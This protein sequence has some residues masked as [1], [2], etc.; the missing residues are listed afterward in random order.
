MNRSKG[1]LKFLFI[2]TAVLGLGGVLEPLSLEAADYPNILLITIDT[3]R[4]D[5]LSC[6]DPAHVATPNIDRLAERGVLFQK[7]FAHTPLTLPSHA[8]ILLG[9]SPVSHGVH[10]NSSFSVP[11]EH[12]TLAEYLKG[13]GYH[14][15][16]FVS[17]TPL[18]SRF[19][20]AQGFDI[21][22]DTFMP[23]GAPKIIGAEQIAESA[24]KKVLGWYKNVKKGPWF[25][26]VHLY[27]PHGDYEPPEPFRL[28]YM[29]RPYEGEVA[30]TDACLGQ[31][32]DRLD[33]DKALGRTIV[34]L[35][36]DHGESLGEH[37][38]DTHG[39][40]AY[41][42]VLHVPL[43]IAAPGVKKRQTDE[44]ACHSDIWPTLCDLAGIDVPGDLQGISLRP[45]LHGK[46]LPSRL[47]YFESLHS[48]YTFGWAPIQGY[49]NSD[50]KFI[51]SPI[52]EH[53]NLAADFDETT[54]LALDATDLSLQKSQLGGLIKRLTPLKSL[55][56]RSTTSP[57][58]LKKLES[59]GYVSSTAARHKTTFGPE[60]DC[61]TLFPILSRTK[62]AYLLKNEGKITEAIRLLES[63]R[64]EPLVVETLYL[65]LSGL[66][67]SVENKTKA[68]A[69]LD[70]GR[71][72]FPENYEILAASVDLLAAANRPLD[73][74]RVMNDAP[75]MMK[76]DQDATI[77]NLLGKAHVQLNDLGNA[78]EVFE[79][80]V[81]V[82]NEFIEALYNLASSRFDL[83]VKTH[84]LALCASAIPPLKR[85]IDLDARNAKAYHLL[86]NAYLESGE[87][88]FAISACNQALNINPAL[89]Q[90]YHSLGMAFYTKGHLAKA[91]EY[92]QIYKS[93]TYDVLSIM[94]QKNLD[95]LIQKCLPRER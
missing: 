61:K 48:Y 89:D 92:L 40:F 95:L 19:G 39:I 36:S 32:F 65:S 46:T 76:M 13:F 1:I 77:W 59:L 66:Y 25:L 81:S 72:R 90:A 47:I 67:L 57:A 18:D 20:L 62:K 52:P 11:Q 70:E 38:E 27:D 12:Q 58:L 55:N 29:A 74:I 9:V 22:D 42:S 24:I 6:Y 78:I 44:L 64:D 31:L 94:E 7:A 3:L 37:G 68:I 34:L 53:Y 51:E 4:A 49:L 85:V 50:E 30:Y 88:D 91:H 10:D 93:K 43:I 86:G 28:Q 26:W 14:T 80:A 41:N 69:V 2:M 63:F 16:A 8:S 84:N 21:Y 71:T 45:A 73:I 75:Y 23:V 17:A 56:A 60:D 15:A 35:T 87:P 82:D 33:K 5:R 83:S 79:R 54:N